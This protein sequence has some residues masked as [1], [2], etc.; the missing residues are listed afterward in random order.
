MKIQ[1]IKTDAIIGEGDVIA[2]WSGG[3]TSAVACRLAIEKYPN[4]RLVYIETGSHHPDTIRFKN[5]CE[6]WYGQEIE[7]LQNKKYENHIDVV[8]STKYVNGAGGARCT[9]ELKKNVR[10]DFEKRNKIAAQ[11]WGY[12]F[13]ANEINRAIRTQEQYG[14]T[15]PLFP[16]IENKLSKKECAGILEGAGIEIPMMYKLGY[17]N[18]NCI[19]CVK[20]GSGYWNKI[21]KDFPEIFKQMAEAEREVKATCLK[22]K[23]GKI[24]LDELDPNA[25]NPTDL[26]TGECGIFCQVDFAYIM[27]KRTKDILEGKESIYSNQPKP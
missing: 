1:Q 9:K 26:I 14:Y 8:L 3:I 15:N 25:G 13:E 16:L 12:E 4:V 18:N 17:N 19:G 22:D 23:D 2:W 11:V 20:G 7:T 21:R 6:K 24:Y 27:S 5:D 10:I